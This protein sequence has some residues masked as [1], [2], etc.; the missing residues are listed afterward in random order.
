MGILHTALNMSPSRLSRND[1]P[2]RYRPTWDWSVPKYDSARNIP[3]S[4]PDQNVYRLRGS[5]E[6]ST[7]LSLPELP[8]RVSAS[9]NE[10]S[11]GNRATR[12][13]PAAAMPAKMTASC[14]FC[15]MFTA[16]FPPATV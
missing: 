15:V 1:A 6:K 9:A 7:A 11:F 3:P 16:S 14:C 10:T 4:R 2:D 5:G 13:M 12:M 8:A